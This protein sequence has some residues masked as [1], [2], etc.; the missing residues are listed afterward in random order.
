MTVRPQDFSPSQPALEVYL[1]RRTLGMLNFDC[2]WET[3]IKQW[4]QCIARHFPSAI[5]F[6][7][8]RENRYGAS[9]VNFFDDLDG[10]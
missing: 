2:E 10:R 5:R 3:T 7:D 9:L 6:V 1:W 4:R 8:M